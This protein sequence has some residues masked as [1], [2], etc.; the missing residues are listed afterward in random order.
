[1]R[2]YSATQ[3]S[4]GRRAASYWF[5]DGFPDIV[6][7]L[8]VIVSGAVGLV[9]LMYA[10]GASPAAVLIIGVAVYLHHRVEPA[11]SQFPEIAFHVSADRLRATAEG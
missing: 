3:N 7:G 2:D 11:C 4:P 1:M 9:W 5:V 8:A 6:F 10:P